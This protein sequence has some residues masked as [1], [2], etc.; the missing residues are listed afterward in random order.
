MTMY[1]EMVTALASLQGV[2]KLSQ[3]LLGDSDSFDILGVGRGSD[4]FLFLPDKGSR[5]SAKDNQDQQD[6][7]DDLSPGASG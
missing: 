1:Q 2:A 4:L 6:N 5:Q 7:E 3:V